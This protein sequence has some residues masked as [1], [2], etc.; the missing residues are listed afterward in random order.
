MPEP[1]AVATRPR[2]RH[3]L[4]LAPAILSRRWKMEDG[5]SA[6]DQGLFAI[7]HPLPSIFVFLTVTLALMALPSLTSLMALICNLFPNFLYRIETEDSTSEATAKASLISGLLFYPESTASTVNRCRRR[8]RCAELGRGDPA[9][10]PEAVEA[11]ALFG[12]AD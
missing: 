12:L 10:V 2:E 8:S 11:E 4:A 6:R 7:L 5:R 3:V 1:S 9:L